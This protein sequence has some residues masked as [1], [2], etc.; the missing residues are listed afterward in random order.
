MQMSESV[1]SVSLGHSQA[2]PVSSVAASASTCDQTQRPQSQGYSLPGHRPHGVPGAP[3]PVPP[4]P[5]P[6]L[7]RTNQ[8]HADP[9]APT[10]LSLRA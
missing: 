4:A 10:P 9:R 5:S 7:Q 1:N 6:R 8:G 3:G 2:H